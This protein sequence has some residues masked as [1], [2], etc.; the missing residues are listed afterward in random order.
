MIIDDEKSR[1]YFTSRIMED[2]LKS[3]T[4]IASSSVLYIVQEFSEENAMK[5]MFVKEMFELTECSL[6]DHAIIHRSHDEQ[7]DIIDLLISHLVNDHGMPLVVE[8]ESV[9]QCLVCGILVPNYP[10]VIQDGRF[11]E[12]RNHWNQLMDDGG[13]NSIVAHVTAVAFY[14]SR[15]QHELSVMR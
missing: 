2:H 15:D 12:L 4:N 14:Y 7:R 11:S 3:A 1:S 5:M 9:M 13:W 10:E 6:C 8:R